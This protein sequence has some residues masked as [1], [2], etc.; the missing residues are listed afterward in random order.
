MLN[1]VV[2][3]GR[4]G[5]DPELRYT[6]SGVAVVSFSLAVNRQ[7]KSQSGEQETDWF[8][9]VAWKQQAEFAANY[10][11]KGR[12]VAVQGRLQARSWVAQDG[13]K[14]NTVEVVAERLT[15]LDRP[16]DQA[17]AGTGEGAPAGGAVMDENDT[18]Y[19]PFAEE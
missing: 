12:L 18:D 5:K 6:P 9:I 11:G 17:A 2:L 15:G 13:T 7:F 1:Q 16:K 4:I 10:L 14:R 8:N 3:I 19:D